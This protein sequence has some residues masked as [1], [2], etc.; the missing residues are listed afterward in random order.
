MIRASEIA[1][2]SAL[3]ARFSQEATSSIDAISPELALLYLLMFRV[4]RSAT[5]CLLGSNPT[6]IKHGIAERRSGLSR[7]AFA[8]V[9]EREVNSVKEYFDLR[10]E[11]QNY[12]P[13]MISVGS[14]TNLSHLPNESI[15]VT[16]SSPPYCTR[17]DYAIATS[18]ELA[19]L[20]SW[21][22]FDFCALRRNLIGTT[23]TKGVSGTANCNWGNLCNDFL[24]DVRS[25]PSKASSAYYYR[26]YIGYFSQ[27]YA[28]LRD[29]T[30]VTVKGGRA[31]IVVQNSYYKEV[32]IDL[33]SIIAEMLAQEGWTFHTR[34]EFP[35]QASFTYLNPSAK[36]Y[37][38]V[39]PPVE[40]AL[41]FLKA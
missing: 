5:N 7:E 15:D 8:R 33:G 28:S 36:C 16:I 32:Q 3:D 20:S 10:S 18:I 41:F 1:L 26:Y 23:L 25:H 17:I 40:S 37:P 30:R 39:R 2:R 38:K 34:K 24:A 11:A 35:V 12:E 6:W 19:M 21:Y 22:P 27:I 4:L 29:I 31:V 9:F 13:P 14:S